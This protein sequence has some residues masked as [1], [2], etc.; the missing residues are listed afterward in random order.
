LDPVHKILE[1]PHGGQ[2]NVEKNSVYEGL[3]LFN[4]EL[5][6]TE[7]VDLSKDP[8][9]V[10]LFKNMSARLATFKT[11][12]VYSS[13]NESECD[14]GSHHKPTPAAPT[15]PTPPTPPPPTPPPTPSFALMAGGKCL[16]AEKDEKHAVL[17]M[18]ACDSTNALQQ[19]YTHGANGQIYLA[20]SERCLKIDSEGEW[21]PSAASVYS[22]LDPYNA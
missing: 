20:G 12:I 2:C 18:S 16:A 15:P 8:A 22:V 14:A 6:P 11:S 13:I 21:A 1:S 17:S 5:D 7:S 3:R 9:H 10:A 4:L 19:W